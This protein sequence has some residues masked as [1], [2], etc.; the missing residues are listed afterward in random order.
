MARVEPGSPEDSYLWHKI[1]GTHESVGGT[2]G[3][4]PLNETPLDTATL[5]V[6]ETWIREGCPE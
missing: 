5:T 4:M 3:Q 1:N 2:G 6:I